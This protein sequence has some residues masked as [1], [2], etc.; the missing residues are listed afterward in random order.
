LQ[1]DVT[2]NA[3]T[4]P[5]E[6]EVEK[7]EP[8]SNVSLTEVKVDIG[9]IFVTTPGVYLVPVETG[10]LTNLN[11]R[12]FEFRLTIENHPA[13]F[14]TIPTSGNG[15]DSAGT[16]T[17]SGWTITG[18][19]NVFGE[20]VLSAFSS[21]ALTG[22]GTLIYLRLYADGYDGAYAVPYFHTI[23]INPS[24]MFNEGQPV[25]RT[26][27]GLMIVVDNPSPTATNTPTPTATN[28]FTP[29]PTATNTFT[30]TPTATPGGGLIKGTLTYPNAI[31]PTVYISN[32]TVASTAGT[33]SV[34]CTSTYP[35]PTAGECTLMGFG[36]GAYTI[37]A[38]KTG[39]PG[40]NGITSMD[41]ARVAQHVANTAAF[42]N[43]Y[44]MISAEVSGNNLITSFDA[45]E[46]A[47]YVVGNTSG[48]GNTGQWRFFVPAPTPTFPI[49]SSVTTRTYSSVTTWITG[50]DWIGLLL[51]EVSGNWNNTGARPAYG[52]DR[53]T[54]VVLPKLTVPVD[55]EVLIPVRVQGS[56]N[57]GIISYEFDL[58]YDPSVLK[59]QAET[60]DL[61]MTVS[62]GLSYV[63]NAKEPGLLKVAV[64]G[65]MPIDQNGV[66]LN[67]KFTA[68]GTHGTMSPL[69]WER[70]VF[71]EGDPQAT[72]TD[73]QVEISAAMSNSAAEDR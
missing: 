49:A 7:I 9:E 65:P 2:S 41:A 68:I 50:E 20:Y 48:I 26:S 61:E 11:V 55:K 62:H 25:A 73:G 4:L 59:P 37:G 66:L 47:R 42:T 14:V 27:A 52:P 46:I 39:G 51:G 17:S 70:L 44:Q 57:K 23:T 64:Y 53:I 10:D 63:V 58:R 40:L 22:S 35:G 38:S 32:A 15:W 31:S 21:T 18:Q 3:G 12:S 34:S 36:T 8:A 54:T 56:A 30:P 19:Q 69:I 5:P 72:A 16:M 33:P 29:T 60:V 45:A 24:F 6:I 28:T 67:L 1:N 13:N 43:N 71:N